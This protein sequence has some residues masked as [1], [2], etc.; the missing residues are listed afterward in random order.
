M[1]DRE[2]LALMAAVIW[3]A[4]RENLN[5]PG[6]GDKADLEGIKE[7]VSYAGDILVEV[8]SYLEQNEDEETIEAEV[9]EEAPRRKR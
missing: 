7:A 8:D 2:L 5:D 4:Q 3:G 9:I 1:S 6:L